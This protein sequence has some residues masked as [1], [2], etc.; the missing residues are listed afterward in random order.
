MERTYEPVTFQ[1]DMDWSCIPD[2]DPEFVWQF[3]RHR[4]FICLGQAW[5]AYRG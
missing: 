2:E 1:E 5:Q 4:S 3:N